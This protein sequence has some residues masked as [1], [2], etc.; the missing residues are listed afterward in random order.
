MQRF[1]VS[2]DD[3]YHEAWPS[4]CMAADGTLVCCYAEADRHG[5]GAVPAP[6]CASVTTKGHLV[7]ADRGRHPHGSPGVRLLH[8]PLHHPAAR[9]HTAAGGGLEQDRVDRRSVRALV[10]PS[11]PAVELDLRPGQRP[12]Q[13]GVAV[14]QPR[15]RPHLERTR[16]D[17]L[18]HH[19]P[20]PE[21]DQRRHAVSLRRPLPHCRRVRGA[22]AV[23]LRGRRAHLVGADHGGG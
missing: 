9:R 4:I 21:A 1:T 16:E 6:W 23:P 12:A 7:A 20:Q 3:R 10:R 2:R 8:V 15:S 22:G 13:R 19:Q 17:R 14:S 5:G 11:R 18:P